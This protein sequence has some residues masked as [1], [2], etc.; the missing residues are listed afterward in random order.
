M[1]ADGDGYSNGTTL[2]SATRP[3][4]DYYLASEL[5]AISGD[6]YDDDPDSYPGATE[7]CG[8]G[9]DNDCDGFVDEGCDS[10]TASVILN[11]PTPVLNDM[12]FDYLGAEYDT[13]YNYQPHSPHWMINSLDGSMTFPFTTREISRSMPLARPTRGCLC[14]ISMCS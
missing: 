8:D 3:G 5:L 9:R 10:S 7:I 2:S 4:A 6:L 11:S 14:A 1:D 12:T 13:V